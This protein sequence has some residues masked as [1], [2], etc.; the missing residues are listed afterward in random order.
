MNIND[1][2]DQLKIIASA[3]H[4]IESLVSSDMIC[5]LSWEEE[6]RMWLEECEILRQ[7]IK[8]LEGYAGPPEVEN[9]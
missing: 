9:E 2:I 4:M 7:I 5:L 8:E 3:N 1:L 6:I